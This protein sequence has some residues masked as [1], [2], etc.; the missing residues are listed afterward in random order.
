MKFNIYLKVVLYLIYCIS[1]DVTM[2]WLVNK[3]LS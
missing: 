1:V 2:Q 3:Y